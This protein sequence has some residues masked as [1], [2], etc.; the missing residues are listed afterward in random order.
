MSNTHSQHL[1]SH[2]AKLDREEGEDVVVQKVVDVE[3]SCHSHAMQIDSEV[4]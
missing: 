1:I 3:Y 4:K 2:L